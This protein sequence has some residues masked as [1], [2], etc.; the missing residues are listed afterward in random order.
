MALTI[1][2]SPGSQSDISPKIGGISPAV[3]ED[4]KG[5]EIGSELSRSFSY[6]AP[7]ALVPFTFEGAT[8]RVTAGGDPWFVLADV[9]KVLEIGNPSQAAARL[10]DDEKMTLTLTEGHSGQ[11]G[12]AQ[13]LNIISEAGFYRLVLRSDKP[14]ADR[15]QSWVVK[16]V[17]PAIRKTG[18]YNLAAPA[19]MTREQIM[20]QALLL[21]DETMKEQAGQIALLAPKAEALD[22]I[23]AAEGTFCMTEAA[24]TLQVKPKVLSHLLQ[25]YPISNVR[26]DFWKYCQPC[27]MRRAPA[28]SSPLRRAIGR[29]GRLE[30]RAR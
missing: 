2:P 23:A 24:K 3:H 25:M 9:C 21:A 16:E 8:V 6:P 27:I 12:G 5:L 26:G 22:R 29:R 19:P 20:A 15:F 4:T 28:R 10:K 11:R 30:C 7:G 1:S 13:S 18:G 14:A 17:L